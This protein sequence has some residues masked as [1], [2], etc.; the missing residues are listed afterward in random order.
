MIRPD[1]RL[2][3]R[4]GHG[5]GRVEGAEQVR[6]EHLAPGIEAHPH[7]QV[8][9][10]DAGVVDEDVD[11]AEG[12]E[13][14]GDQGLGGFGLHDVAGLGHRAP[15]ERLDRDGRV[16]R[17][18]LV[19]AVAE[20]DVRALLREAQHDRPADAAR[21]AGHHRALAVQVDHRAFS[22]VTGSRLDATG[23][24]AGFVPLRPL[25]SCCSPVGSGSPSPDPL[26]LA[27]D[28][29]V[30]IELDRARLGEDRRQRRRDRVDRAPIVGRADVDVL[31]ADRR[32]ATAVGRIG[33][34]ADRHGA[35]R[36]A[37][38]ERHDARRCRRS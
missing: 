28:D 37:G 18:D 35:R 31:G 26:G 10:G 19:A 12:A 16:A 5:L 34:P 2:E 27:R 20:R 4:P 22:L 13:G 24:G 29:I 36:E 3:H 33:R 6:L 1:W 17:R 38:T 11:L 7:D 14:G 30:E 8:V 23:S 21:A 25:C 15:A 9:A 32:G